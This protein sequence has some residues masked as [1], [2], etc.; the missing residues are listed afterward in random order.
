MEKLEKLVK[1][2][3]PESNGESTEEITEEKQIK[4]LQDIGKLLLTEYIIQVGDLT[5]KPLLVEAYYYHQ[6]KFND[7]NSHGFGDKKID[8]KCREQ[9]SDNFNRFYFHEKKGRGGVDVCLSKGDYCLSF[10]IKVA[11]INGKVYKQI[12]IYNKLIKESIDNPKDVLTPT[13]DV[14]TSFVC[15]PRKNTHKGDY[16]LKPLAILFV[17][18]FK[19]KEEADAI[20]SSLET[21]Y[22][23][24]WVLAKY[25]QEKVGF[26]YEEACEIIKRENLYPYKIERQYF[27]GALNYMKEQEN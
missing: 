26:D 27:D 15:V 25:A 2:L 5:I 24:Q 3:A 19:N 10:L 21:G 4:T 1:E 6:G 8:K 23:K 7:S 20:L 18:S 11:L 22:K 12:D 13:Y 14:T 17:E 16:A 9:L